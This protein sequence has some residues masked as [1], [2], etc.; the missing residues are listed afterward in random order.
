MTSIELKH[1]AQL[2]EWASAIKECRSSGRSVREWCRQQGITPT[3]YY[4]WEREVLSVAGSMAQQEG[5]DR[6]AFAKVPMPRQECRNEAEHSATLYVGN[7]RMDI[8]PSCG[9]EQ[10]KILVEMLHIC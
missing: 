2:Q 7:V 10:L 5:R 8:Y 6:V 4:R 1:Q 3:T 9:R